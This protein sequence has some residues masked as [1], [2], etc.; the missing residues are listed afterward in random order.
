MMA[1][2]LAFNCRNIAQSIAATTTRTGLKIKSETD[3]APYSAGAM[4]LTATPGRVRN[5]Q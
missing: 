1:A 3:T 4:F 2:L 5:P